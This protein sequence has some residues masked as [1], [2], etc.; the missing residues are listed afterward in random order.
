VIDDASEPADTPNS[1]R[2]R[3]RFKVRAFCEA[4][5]V[6]HGTYYAVPTNSATA[7]IHTAIAAIN[8]EPGDEVPAEQHMTGGHGYRT[9]ARSIPAST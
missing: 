2:W 1:Q 7:A 3:S 5:A 6:R 4:F 9:S 8:P